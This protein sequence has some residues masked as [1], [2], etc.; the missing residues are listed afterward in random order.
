GASGRYVP[1]A[2]PIGTPGAGLRY[3][4]P[5]ALHRMLA[6]EFPTETSEQRRALDERITPPGADNHWGDAFR[7]AAVAASIS[8]VAV[9]GEGQT[10]SQ[11]RL[12]PKSPANT[13]RPGAKRG[14]SQTQS[15]AIP[16]RICFQRGN[17]R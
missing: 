3:Q 17:L 13:P 1:A 7:L 8:G 15:G 6:I 14:R 4:S 2:E 16:L 9:P 12:R 11:A 5:H 10:R